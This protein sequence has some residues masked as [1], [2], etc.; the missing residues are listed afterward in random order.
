[1]E[2]IKSVPIP[3]IR[4]GYPLTFIFPI[5][6]D[7]MLMIE[8]AFLKSYNLLKVAVDIES[9]KINKS[10]FIYKTLINRE[11]RKC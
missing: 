3:F 6:S 7:M 5:S 1:V 8:K 9:R 2:G 11:G 4:T 10:I